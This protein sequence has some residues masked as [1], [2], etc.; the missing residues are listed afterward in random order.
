MVTGANKDGFHLRNV[1]VDRDIAV[2][3]WADLHTV[4]ADEECTK[5]GGTLMLM[6]GLEIGHI[7]KLGT[8]YSEI[9]NASVLGPDGNRTPI[10]MGSYGIGVER[11]IAAVA[12]MHHDEQGLTWP[13]SL[14]PFD[15]VVLPVNCQDK[16][17]LSVAEQICMQLKELGI[18]YLLDDRNERA[19]VKF[20]DADLIGVPFRIT[21]GKKVASGQV[22]LTDRTTRSTVN[23]SV[24]EIANLLKEKL[25]STRIK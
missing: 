23:V 5:C 22:E 12:E 2:D 9:M 16:Q 13:V 15:V 17:Q 14:A 20:N 3:L 10:V 4:R 18:D 21:I 7:F 1:C 25:V 19:G 6:K 8:R 24:E 11:L